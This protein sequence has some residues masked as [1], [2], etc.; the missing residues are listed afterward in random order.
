MAK[1]FVKLKLK[2]VEYTFT[3]LDFGQ[4]QDLEGPMAILNSMT[5]DTMPNAEQRAAII[6]VIAASLSGKHPELQPADVAR[7]LTMANIA[8]A[9]K[10]VSGVSVLEDESPSG[11]A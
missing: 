2:D 8:A 7:L 1:D 10:A 9:L 11:N 6:A 5:N 3:A 4:L